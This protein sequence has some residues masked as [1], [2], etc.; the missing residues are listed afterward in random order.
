[1]WRARGRVPLAAEVSAALVE[2][3][4]KDGSSRAAQADGLGHSECALRSQYALAV[5]R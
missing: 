4:I 3:M 2:T 1:V 5:I